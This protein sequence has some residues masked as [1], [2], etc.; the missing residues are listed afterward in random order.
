MSSPRWLSPQLPEL[1]Q[2]Q[3]IARIWLPGFLAFA[4]WALVLY[5]LGADDGW[6]WRL[7]AIIP[8]A[9]TYRLLDLHQEQHGP[10]GRRKARR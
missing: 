3:R 7:V 1:T 4:A 2:G 10:Y 6:I 8:L 9:Y 5:A